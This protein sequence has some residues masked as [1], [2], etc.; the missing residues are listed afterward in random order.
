MHCLDIQNNIVYYEIKLQKFL[1][2]IIKYELK[3]L[4]LMEKILKPDKNKNT[5]KILSNLHFIEEIF[6]VLQN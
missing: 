5:R 4:I 3:I 6:K 2:I 1:T